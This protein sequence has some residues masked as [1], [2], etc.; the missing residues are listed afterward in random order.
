LRRERTGR[1]ERRDDINPKRDQLRS[2][3]GKQ[4]EIAVRRAEFEIDVLPFDI[5]KLS[6]AVAQL[7]PEGFGIRISQKKS[8][9]QTNF[10]PLSVRDER[11]SCRH[12]AERGHE[13]PPSDAGCH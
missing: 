8:A 9:D 4:I 13:L 6:Q 11:P 1:V 3:L 7:H 5:A 2:E 10:R 12:A